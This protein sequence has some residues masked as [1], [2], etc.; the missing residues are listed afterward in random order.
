[1]PTLTEIL[2]SIPTG[3]G[4]LL[5]ATIVFDVLHFM[6]HQCAHSSSALLRA[7]GEMHQIHHRF[8]DTNLQ[9]HRELIS[10]NAWCH[11]IPEFLI[12][13]IV[14]CLLGVLFSP[15]AVVVALSLEL[16]VFL[17]IIKPTPGFDI[18]HH[19]VEK[20]EA[21]RPLYFCVPEYHLLHH[22]HPDAYFSSWIKTLDHLL[23]TGISLKNRRVAITGPNTL[24][25]KSL[26]ER[27][28]QAGC[29][30]VSANPEN[31]DI[32]VVCHEAS[33]AN[34]YQDSITAY[35][36]MHADNRM[37]VEVWVLSH[38]D[39]FSTPQD[40]TYACFATQLF[41]AEKVIYRHLVACHKNPDMH[42]VD[43]LLHKIKM[44]FN[45]VPERYSPAMLKHYGQ[46]VLK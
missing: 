15:G 31:A 12:Q 39:E 20:L 46:F 26:A 8:L 24:F 36:Q 30:E 33:S 1:M 40:A 6:L 43:S 11:V 17:L 37:P 13:V 5:L 38:V 44:G 14:T 4:L 45:Y 23:G 21:Y 25:G 9:I 2:F 10:A 35:Y 28:Q 42:A 32:L 41:S 19:P 3:I 29:Q 27:L 34:D 16:L 18:N 22:V 7:A